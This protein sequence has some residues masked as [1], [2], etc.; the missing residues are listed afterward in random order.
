[1]PQLA[2]LSWILL[3]VGLLLIILFLYSSIWWGKKCSL[4]TNS[5]WF[6]NDGF[7]FWSW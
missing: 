1:M 3:P 2:P 6:K 5:V 7:F 4:A